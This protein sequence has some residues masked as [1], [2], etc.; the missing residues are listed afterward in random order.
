MISDDKIISQDPR[1]SSPAVLDGALI[2]L[3]F[4]STN[5]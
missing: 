2:I 4:C 3:V 1:K 5:K